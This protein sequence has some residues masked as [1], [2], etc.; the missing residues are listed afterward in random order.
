ME[1]QHAE[2]EQY[3]LDEEPMQL[4]QPMDGHQFVEPFLPAALE[5][6]DTPRGNAENEGPLPF[7][8]SVLISPFPMAG[9]NVEGGQAQG[10]L[11]ERNSSTPIRGMSSTPK[12]S[13]RKGSRLSQQVWSWSCSFLE[14]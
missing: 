10:I 13:P 3:R 12:K 4:D 14:I 2:Q 6:V 7:L 5:R 11:G 9:Q 1:R 8:N